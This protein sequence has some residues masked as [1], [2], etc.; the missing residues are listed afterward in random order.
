MQARVYVRRIRVNSVSHLHGLT[1]QFRR[2]QIISTFICQ[3][4]Y[5]SN[6]PSLNLHHLHK[7]APP[8]QTSIP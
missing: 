2:T 5:T 8:F 4:L 7:Y 3:F 6:I 1:L